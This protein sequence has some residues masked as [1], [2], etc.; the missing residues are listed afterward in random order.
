M[1][2]G[3]KILFVYLAFVAGIMFMVYKTTLQKEDLVTTDYYS[4][5]LKYQQ[6]I[7]A[8]RRT[9]SLPEP[10]EYGVQGNNFVVHFPKYFNGKSLI[11]K[12][13]LFCPSDAHKDVKHNFTILGGTIT[14]PIT[15]SA[16]TNYDLHL[17][18]K[19]D[20]LDYYLERKVAI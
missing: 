6:V 10:V 18:W 19:V 9:D 4:K 3:Y 11:G 12:L 5:E 14:V 20:G 15:P 17:S 8:A 7:D 13:I 16:T 1:N 2:W